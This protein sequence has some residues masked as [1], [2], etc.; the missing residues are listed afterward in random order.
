M[1]KKMIRKTLVTLMAVTVTISSSAPV[2]AADDV[3]KEETVYV[4]TDAQGNEKTVIVSDWLKNF[5]GESTL[6]DASDL[7]DIENVK[8][9]ETFSKKKDDILWNAN[10]NDIYYQGKSDKELPVTM[11]VTYYLNDKKIKPK[12]LIGK[13]GKVRIRYSYNNHSKKTATI[14]GKQTTVYT[15]FTLIT[16]AIL[17]TDHFSNVK[18]SN[19]KVISDGSKHMV[20]GVSF[21]GLSDSLDLKNSSFGSTYSIPEN[22]EITADAKDFQMTVTAT[23]AT[24]DTLS[25]FGL[26][27]ADSINDLTDCLNEMS[28]ASEKLVNGSGDL[29]SGVNQLASASKELK[30]GTS[31]L[32]KSSK[33]LTNGLNTLSNGSKELKSGTSQLAS[34]TKDLPTSVAK[35][36]KGVKQIIKELENG[37][38]SESKQ[39]QLQS[40]L[41]NTQSQIK[42]TMKDMAA[43]TSALGTEAQKI[44]ELAKNT[45]IPE[46][47]RTQLDGIAQN[48]SQNLQSMKSDLQTM[49]SSLNTMS[50]CL[51][52]IS[53]LLQ[54]TKASTTKLDTALKQISTGT[55]QLLSS[56]KTL[57]S[58]I[59]QL[60]QGASSLNSGIKTAANGSSKLS[61]GASTLNQGTGQLVTGV[62]TLQKGTSDLNT[63]MTTFNNTGIQN[64]VSLVNNDVKE[65]LDRANAV[66]SAGTDYQTFTK[67]ANGTKGSVKFMIE[68]EELEK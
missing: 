13:S 40:T 12:N 22:F 68:T 31:K 32:S 19:G 35:L 9:N 6:K 42:T 29:L 38:P 23:V 2:F 24:A 48:M 11:N 21:P 53:G 51:N 5:T 33:E 55:E 28:N 45:N 1:R 39:K 61:S 41:T 54:D 3:D 18:A 59:H 46:S 66:M 17:S 36:D 37:M 27:D 49:E 63:G 34:K 57:T 50:T 64:L 30:S 10:G 65:T 52:T 7:T 20:V 60:D 15:P 44:G 26:D 4:K 8:G 56:S 62:A 67:K 47:E 43:Q 14:D 25:E 58:S 16:A